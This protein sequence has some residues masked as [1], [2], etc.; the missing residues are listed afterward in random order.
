MGSIC[1]AWRVPGHGSLFRCRKAS[2]ALNHYGRRGS[3]RLMAST[4]TPTSTPSPAIAADL[5]VAHEEAVEILLSYH[6]ETK[7]SF[8]KYARGPSGLDWANQPNP[9]R[10]YV[11]APVI[12]L[13]HFA[14]DIGTL[15]YPEVGSGQV[16]PQTLT[17]SALSQ[18]LYDSLALSAWKSIGKSSWSLRVNPSSGNLHP[19]EGYVIS[20]PILGVSECPFVA[21]YAPKEH[22]LE[23]RAEFSLDLW[24]SL[25]K[26]LPEGS[27][28]VGLTSIYWREAWKY[29]E[30]AFRY[31]NHDVGHAIGAVTV[32][33]AHLGWNAQLLDG[34]GTSELNHL[35]GLA[36]TS[37]APSR[38]GSASSSQS[39]KGVFPGLER[40][41][42]DCV[43]ALFPWSRG[44]ENETLQLPVLDPDVLVSKFS[45]LQFL[46]QAN[47]LSKEH[48]RWDTIY[49]A[50][51]AS[52]KPSSRTSVPAHGYG[53]R[54]VPD[55]LKNSSVYEDYTVRQV[56]RRRRS[57]VDMDGKFGMQRDNFYQ[58]LLKATVGTPGMFPYG[59]LT[60]APEV[61][62]A[63]F[64]HRIVD[65]PQGVYFLVRNE[66]HETGLKEACRKNFHWEKPEGCP[67]GLPLYR[68][69]T[70]DARVLA[71]RLSCNQEIAGNSFFSLGMIARFQPVLR[72]SG[73]WMYPR[74]FW[75]AGV[76]GQVLYLEA[77][78]LGVA[79]T[80]IGCYFDDAVHE[81]LGLEDKEFQSLY[82][83]TIGVPIND[84]RIMNLPAYPGPAQDA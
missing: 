62:C 29:G 67:P 11:G 21:H 14:E 4:P 61:H 1:K 26:G 53:C 32:A 83:F 59:V 70:G 35:M 74:L 37:S 38:T 63:I 45:Q 65:L 51:L 84:G 12:H 19:T 16:E 56:V 36:S 52:H 72:E 9:F 39:N 20:G 76:L 50:S 40:E 75:E 8:H 27:I 81:L 48:L 49:T 15:P 30:R 22:A 3:V 24:E 13:E 17:K 47:S 41:S 69:L 10:R 55:T 28:L 33:A 60:W 43:L 31:C 42:A 64:V 18:L 25:V 46:G 34:Y 23:I 77:T 54:S 71:A 57:A 80:G 68:L 5:P 82:H 7:H 58:L 73:P 44:P 79:A 78:A 66:A 6:Q 2:T